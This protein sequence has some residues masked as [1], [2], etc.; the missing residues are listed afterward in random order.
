MSRWRH[1]P[2]ARSPLSLTALLAGAWAAASRN[3]KA[4]QAAARVR[5]L[6]GERYAARDVLLTGSG[7]TALSAA[8]LAVLKERPGAAVALPAYGCYDLA[9]AAEGANAPVRLYDVDPRTLAPDLAQVESVLRQGV[10]AI[11]VVHLYGYPVDLDGVNDLAAIYGTVVIED[12]AQAIGATLRERPAGTQSALAVLSFGRGKGLTGGSGG[13][14]LAHDAAGTRI[15]AGARGLLGEGGGAARQGWAELL[16]L[17]GQFLLERPS[18][19][20]LPASLPF[21]RLGETIHRRPLALRGPTSASCSVVA[22]TWQL[23][24]REAE[25][26]RRN[27]ER[28]LRELW[29]QPGFEL[30]TSH[31]R[32]R[33]GYLRLP[34]LASP[35]VRRAVAESRA[36]RL[37]VM[38]G[39]PRILSELDRFRPRCLNRDEAFPGSRL[40][41]TRLCTLPTHSRLLARD[42]AELERWVRTQGR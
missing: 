26:R 31:R 14:L 33:P 36:R 20:A 18:V 27:A 1:Q 15:L 38:P 17:T 41:T 35:A 6:L 23:A 22:G 42:L 4:A 9:T 25:I 24:E 7:T 19:Y 29:A 21:L 5:T 8:L 3:G 10:A 30:I 34:V 16:A 37:G 40:L 2:P 32:A 28:L 13:A 11:V 12:A 39:Y